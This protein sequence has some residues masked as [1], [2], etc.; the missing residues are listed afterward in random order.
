MVVKL[1]GYIL[2]DRGINYINRVTFKSQE[3]NCI[4]PINQAY[5]FIY[6]KMGKVSLITKEFN[7]TLT[8]EQE[9]VVNKIKV[10]SHFYITTNTCNTLIDSPLSIN[11]ALIFDFEKTNDYKFI[12]RLFYIAKQFI[13]FLCYRRDVYLPNVDLYAPYEN[14]KYL[15]FATLHIIDEL[16]SCDLNSLKEKRYISQSLIVGYEGKILADIAD[17][18][19]YL[20]HLPETYKSGRLIDASRFIMIMAA[21]EWEFKRMY[22]D[23]IPKDSNTIQIEN[24]AMEA[25]EDLI[26]KS[27]GKLKKKYKFLKNLISSDNLQ[28]KIIKT[29]NDFDDAIGNFGKN[30]YELNNEILD[31]SKMGDRLANQRN[32]FAH[33]NLNKDFIGF[34]LL[35]LIYLEYI[36]YAM[37]LR[38]YGISDINIRKAINN[39]FRLNYYI[40]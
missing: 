11:S 14:V 1:I 33:G 13:Q 15:K 26:N 28:S 6:E 38:Y 34:S 31:Y 8:K 40:E 39:L 22:P 35:D 36:I 37:Q 4:Y 19:L 32:N 10:K 25:I 2:C 7:T 20:R 17:N 21:F 3:I 23:G 9:F 27:K 29:G 30:L 12:L 24:E 18:L 16:H 5:Q